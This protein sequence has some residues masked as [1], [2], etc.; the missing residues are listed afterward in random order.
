[1]GALAHIEAARRRLRGTWRSDRK[2][3]ISNWVFPKRLA[4]RRYKWFASLFGKNTWHFGLKLCSGTF[5]DRTEVGPYRILWADE[6]SAVVLFPDKEGDRCHHLFFDGDHF[7]L[8]AGGAGNAEYFKRMP[9][10]RSL[11][12]RTRRKR[13]A[14][15]LTR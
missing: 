1:M 4:A 2:R 6:Y 8:V 15:E 5:E 9:S 10:N 11:Q 7:Y 12:K 3:T 14:A 13:R